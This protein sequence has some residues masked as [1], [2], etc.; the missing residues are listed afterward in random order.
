MTEQSIFADFDAPADFYFLQD[1]RPIRGIRVRRNPLDVEEDARRC[2]SLC[3]EAQ[4][5]QRPLRS[6]YTYLSADSLL[7]AIYSSSFNQTA[8]FWPV[9]TVF[10]IRRPVA[11][12]HLL[13][14]APFSN[15]PPYN[16]DIDYPGATVVSGEWKNAIE[17]V[18]PNRH[19]F[20]PVELHFSDC[21]ERNYFYLFTKNMIFGL[22]ERA[23]LMA[24]F[25][26]RIGPYP[27]RFIIRARRNA[28]TGLHWVSGP[29]GFIAS[30]ELTT[31][32]RRIFVE[33]EE[34][35]MS[36]IPIKLVDD[37]IAKTHLE[38]PKLRHR[39]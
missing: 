22:D 30:A 21:V 38:F 11:L 1:D 13:C 35:G 14:L 18:E 24:D 19:I 7:H 2:K 8:N 26:K 34:N 29:E 31:L 3:E 25:W 12:A 36:F 16:N 23:G 10:A 28:V 15:S 27:P 9:R 4:K 37:K 20:L 32:L 33:D 5:T 6:N 17:Q 39:F